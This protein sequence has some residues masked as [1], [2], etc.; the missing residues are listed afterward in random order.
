VPLRANC[1]PVD[2]QMLCT[3]CGGTEFSSSPVLWRQL[4]DEWQLSPAEA[5]YVDRQQ[6]ECCRN[7]GANLRS[8]ALADALRAACGTTSL[9]CEFVS[10]A[11]AAGVA[12]LELN[13]AGTLNPALSKMPGHVFAA[14]PKTDI[15][16]MPWPDHTFDIVVH[17]DT[18]EHVANPV[19]ALGECRRILKP[20]GTLCLTVPIIVG[21]MTRNRCGL[22]KSYHG[23]PQEA[24]DDYVVHTE[25]GADAWCFLM[26]AGYSEVT[27][28][29]IA[30][31]AALAM[32]ARR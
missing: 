22:P 3:I 7:C 25:F 5:A 19:H 16:A 26:E 14:Y 23:S 11:E 20:G 18:L 13:A 17:S 32:A 8:I 1:H 24:G 12:M 6:G 29:H 27:I 9:L 21:R 10:S 2:T 30:Y 31:P 4:V 15:H 28:F